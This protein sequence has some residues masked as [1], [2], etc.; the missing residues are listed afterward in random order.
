TRDASAC[1]YL[2]ADPAV[3]GTPE[4]LEQ[5]VL[6]AAAATGADLE[7]CA[8]INVLMEPLTADRDARLHAAIP[9]YVPLHPAAAG[10]ARLAR[11]AGGEVLA[12]DDPAL[13]AHLAQAP[14]RAPA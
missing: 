10:H 7:A 1:L 13:A 9:L 8:D 2:L 11:A 4:Q 12:P 5:C 6:Q 3:E 14:V